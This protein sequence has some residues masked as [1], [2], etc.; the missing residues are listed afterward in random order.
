MSISQDDILNAVADM[1]VMDVV[2][3]IEAMSFGKPIISTNIKDSGVNFVNKHNITGFRAPIK[4]SK[5]LSNLILRLLSNKRIY[6]DI[7]LNSKKRYQQ[8]FTSNKINKIFLNMYESD[9]ETY[10]H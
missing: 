8:Y 10:K 6:S 2:A 9:Y 1:S 7:S 4:N 3:L 5:K